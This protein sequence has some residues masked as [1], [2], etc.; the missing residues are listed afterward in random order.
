MRIQTKNLTFTVLIIFRSEHSNF[1]A[2]VNAYM[3]PT[4][5]GPC[6]IHGNSSLELNK[7]I[8]TE[9]GQP[10]MQVSPY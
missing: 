7:S 6:R 1:V 2:E 8:V 10:G 3:Q 9:S 5:H 4:R